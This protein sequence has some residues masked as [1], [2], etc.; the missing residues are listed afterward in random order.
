MTAPTRTSDILDFLASSVCPRLRRSPVFARW[1]GIMWL[2]L[3]MCNEVQAELQFMTL[4]PCRQRPGVAGSGIP[5]TSRS[6]ARFDEDWSRCLTV[7]LPLLASGST[8]SPARRVHTPFSFEGLWEG[9]WFVSSLHDG[10]YY[11][12]FLLPAVIN[13][14]IPTLLKIQ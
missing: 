13:L 9:K 5:P 1:V 3:C 14:F 2:I 6:S 12:F 7:G 4:V 11:F 8:S 10:F